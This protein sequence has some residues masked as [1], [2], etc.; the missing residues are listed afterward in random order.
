MSHE[1]RRPAVENPLALVLT[2]DR[3]EAVQWEKALRRYGNAGLQRL[4]D[5]PGADPAWAL[6]AL[7]DCTEAEFSRYN[8]KE[9]PNEV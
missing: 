5:A 8:D 7:A 3:V 1:S 6:E 9:S 4:A 2:D